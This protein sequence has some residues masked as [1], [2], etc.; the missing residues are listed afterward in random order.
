MS[1]AKD[2]FGNYVIQKIFDNNIDNDKITRIMKSL[3][4]HIQELTLHMYGCRV[5]QKAI[6][7]S[8]VFKYRLSMQSILGK[9]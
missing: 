3:E 1:L 5:I 2:V 6:E 4:G 7:V 9:S 8:Y